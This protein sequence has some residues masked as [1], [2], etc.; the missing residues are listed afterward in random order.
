MPISCLL[1][2]S[3]IMETLGEGDMSSTCGGNPICT[4]ASHAILDI[5][6]EEKL[7]ENALS[8]GNHMKYRLLEMKEKSR[9]L[10]DVRG[11]GLVI[12]LDIVKNKKTKERDPET[13]RKIITKCCENGLLIGAVSGNVIRVA[14]PL[15]IS[16]D[17][18]DESIDIME[19]VLLSL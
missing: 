19:K 1:A 3:R 6:E 9:C 12:G 5:F 16:R 17:E 8:I 7:V 13:T 2:E 4:A 15:V 14:P 11:R 10:G 18:A